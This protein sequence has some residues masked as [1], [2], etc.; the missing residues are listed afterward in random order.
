MIC[1]ERDMECV[2]NIFVDTSNCLNPCSGL[3]VTTFTQSKEDRKLEELFPVFEDYNKYKIITSNPFGLL[4]KII[5]ELYIEFNYIEYEQLLS[6]PIIFK[7]IS[8]KTI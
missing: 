2:N 6:F 1:S 7:I 5:H 8:G 3:I 4:G